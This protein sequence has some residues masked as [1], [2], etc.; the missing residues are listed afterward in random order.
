MPNRLDTDTTVYFYEN[1]FYPLSNFSAFRLHWNG[2]DF[3][4]S[5][6]AYHWEKFPHRRDIG[7]EIRCARSAHEA[8]KIAERRRN[9]YRPDWEAV[10]VQMMRS[11]L[12]AKVDQHDYVRRKLMETGSRTLVEDSWRDAFWGIGSQGDGQ[13]MLGH[14]WMEIRAT[15]QMGEQH[16]PHAGRI[17]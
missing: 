16:L 8:F 14:L 11:I 13:N 15:L 1:E 3:D 17:V 12:R 7:E 4:T 9:E 10:R 6:A 2:H 5:E